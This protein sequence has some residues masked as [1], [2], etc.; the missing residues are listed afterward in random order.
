ME[1]NQI[2]NEKHFGQE[3]PSLANP[4]ATRVPFTDLKNGYV[5]ITSPRISP[6]HVRL[7]RFRVI[8]LSTLAP[9]RCFILLTTTPGIQFRQN[10]CEGLGGATGQFTLAV[11]AACAV[12]SATNQIW[13]VRLPQINFDPFVC[14]KSNYGF[15]VCH[16]LNL[17]RS[18]ARNQI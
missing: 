10:D 2:S 13:F 3:K 17:A 6:S 8:K 12:W 14:H 15:C 11:L 18:S 5:Q 16:K 4:R 9:W 1:T 7:S